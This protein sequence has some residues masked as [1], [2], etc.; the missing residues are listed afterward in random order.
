MLDTRQIVIL[1]VFILQG[2]RLYATQDY[3]EEFSTTAGTMIQTGVILLDGRYIEPPYQVSR[4]G[5][6]LYINDLEIKRPKRHMGTPILQGVEHPDTLSDE[7][8][9]KLCRNLEETRQVYEKKLTEGY[10]YLFCSTGGYILLSPYAVAYDLP[11]IIEKLSSPTLTQQQKIAKVRPK[12]WHLH[13][14]IEPLVTNLRRSTTLDQRLKKMAEQLLRI[15]EFGT[16]KTLVVETGFLFYGGQYIEAPYSI[17]RKGLGIF[18]NGRLLRRPPKWP[19]EDYNIDKNPEIPTGITSETSWYDEAIQRYLKQKQAYL[20]KRYNHTQVTDTMATII[21]GF[22]FV[23]NS[24][25]DPQDPYILHITTTEGLEIPRLLISLESF[26]APPTR[27]EI[28]SSINTQCEMMKNALAEGSC[29]FLWLR[30]G[31]CWWPAQKALSGLSY[32]NRLLSSDMS[33]QGKLQKLAVDS[34]FTLDPVWLEEL[35]ENFSPCVQLEM[36]V[37]EIDNTP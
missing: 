6:A 33:K 3:F 25:R 16:G 28:I 8:R 17:Q 30:G 19:I 23:T 26:E 15:D 18:I 9:Q 14:N 36:R 4:R 5:L 12:N 11:R 24:R 2:G 34:D 31:Q 10:G 7:D 27:Q 29:G 13:I 1:I 20:Q 35:V 22:P 21:S 32:I 37:G